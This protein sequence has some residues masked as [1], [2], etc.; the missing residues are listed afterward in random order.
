MTI[1]TQSM[2][3]GTDICGTKDYQ[4][5]G[6]RRKSPIF[7]PK[8]AEKSDHSLDPSIALVQVRCETTI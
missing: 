7:S 5:I 6:F 2:Y 1:L 3:L 4:N 8:I